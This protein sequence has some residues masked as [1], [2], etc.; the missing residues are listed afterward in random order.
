MLHS[1]GYYRIISNVLLLCRRWVSAELT[2]L[3]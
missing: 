3:E 2:F 1:G